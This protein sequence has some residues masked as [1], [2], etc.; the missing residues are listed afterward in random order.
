MSLL[1]DVPNRPQT[2]DGG[3]DPQMDCFEENAASMSR[4]LGG[5]LTVRQAELWLYEHGDNPAGGTDINIGSRLLTAYNMPNHVAAQGLEDAANRGHYCFALVVSNAS[6]IPTVNGGHLHY[7]TYLGEGWYRN[8]ANG[9]RVNSPALAPT[10]TGKC[11]E[12][13]LP[14]EVAPRPTQEET[15]MLIVRQEDTGAIY[16]YGPNGL[17]HVGPQEMAVIQALANAGAKMVEIHV[18][19]AG[20]LA[21]IPAV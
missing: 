13:D 20:A 21:G 7:V 14:A 18:D 3:Q 10:Y 2:Q 15:A 6:G 1:P 9:T 19:N 5:N 17:R 16:T 12:I 11:V 8:P 4:L